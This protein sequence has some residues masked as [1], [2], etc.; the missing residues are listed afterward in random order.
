[1]LSKNIKYLVGVDH[2]RGMAAL[3][4]LLY[5]STQLIGASIVHHG[6]GFV[7]QTDYVYTNWNILKST[8]SEGSFGVALFMTL[9]GFI[10]AFGLYKKDLKIK[11]FFRNRFVRI[12]PLYIFL[13]FL[14]LY[15]YPSLQSNPLES[16]ALS[17]FPFFNLSTSTSAIITTG[18]IASAGMFWAIAVECQFYLVFPFLM[19]FLNE[20]KFK[21]LWGIIGLFTALRLMAYISGDVNMSSFGYYSIFGRMDEFIIGMMAA[22][23]FIRKKRFLRKSPKIY[24]LLSSIGLILMLFIINRVRQ[25][26]GFTVFENFYVILPSI[27]GL[28]AA[29]FIVSYVNIF[30]NKSHHLISRLFAKLGELSYSIYLTHFMIVILITTKLSLPDILG[31]WWWSALLYGICLVLPLTLGLSLM[32]YN[33]IEKPFLQLRKKYVIDKKPEVAQQAL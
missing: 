9:S 1:M 10:F 33:F 31:S 6:F 5:H 32:T 17:I 12:Y 22:Y 19:K 8:I 27:E 25:H 29:S 24:L 18:V 13:I 16:I 2:I 20:H 28:I 23:F 14:S 7:A 11:G 15:L 30:Q 21:I 3:L 26:F 4:V